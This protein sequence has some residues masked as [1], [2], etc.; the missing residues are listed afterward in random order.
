MATRTE[1]ELARGDGSTRVGEF[2]LEPPTSARRARLPE[3]VVGLVVMLAFA[4][5]AALWHMS[6]VERDPTLALAR[7]VRQGEIIE[8]SDLR[9]VYLSSDG[10]VARLAEGDVSRVAGRVALTDLPRGTVLTPA[11][12]AA[13]PVLGEGEG[14]VGLALEP[15][16]FPSAGLRPGDR[17][18]VVA[19]P[20][21]QSG[22]EGPG[23]TLL[24]EEAEVFSV[25]D[26]EGGQG[27]RF[28][29]LKMPEATA[30]EVAAAAERGPVRLVLV[31]RS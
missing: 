4:L 2:S 5:A 15:G 17:V 11:L 13:L 3:L 20:A 30:N 27:R 7:D 10:D 26:L 9:V 24:A 29:S 12:V 31:A 6:S 21:S 1:P 18:N 14:V 16:Q 28:V 22:G 23:E 8:A 19:G 25:E